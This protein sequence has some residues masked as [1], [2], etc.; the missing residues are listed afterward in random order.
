MYFLFLLQ[1]PAD[2]LQTQLEEPPSPT[3]LSI[4]TSPSSSPSVTVPSYSSRG[5]AAVTT[6]NSN[7]L[8]TFTMKQV[9]R[10]AVVGRVSNGGLSSGGFIQL[11]KYKC[12]SC[13]FHGNLGEV[14]RHESSVHGFND[15]QALE[16]MKQQQQR[17][18]SKRPIPNLIPIQGQSVLKPASERSL[19]GDQASSS[20]NS[21]VSGSKSNSPTPPD[22]KKRFE[23]NFKRKNASFFDKLKD[24]LAAERDLTCVICGYEAKCLS[25][26]I[27]HRRTHSEYS[28]DEGG[29]VHQSGELSSTRCQ[30]CRHRCKTSADLVVHL[31]TCPAVLSSSF[32]TTIT[33]KEEPHDRDEIN[34]KVRP[35]SLGFL[36]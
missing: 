17:A 28:E 34:Y 27:M 10:P 3:N 19:P 20:A 24:R 29:S 21:S 7:Q 33:I 13:D 35:I 32:E 23:E 5:P 18:S 1:N 2:F 11:Q 26:Q 12:K 15:L 22:D 31:K 30:H 25:E 36:T 6:A 16:A 8:V 4:P 14:Q 9:L